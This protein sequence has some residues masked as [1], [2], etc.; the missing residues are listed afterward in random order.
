MSIGQAAAFLIVAEMII[1]VVAVVTAVLVGR[2]I[3]RGAREMPPVPED[4][5]AQP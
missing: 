2:F 3:R 5:E 1:I 4:Q